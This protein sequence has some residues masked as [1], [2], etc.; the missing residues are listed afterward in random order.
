MTSQYRCVHSGLCRFSKNED[1]DCFG[2]DYQIP[3]SY[4]R[5]DFQSDT[6]ILNELIEWLKKHKSFD[7]PSIRRFIKIRRG[8]DV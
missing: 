8:G 6:I 2:E 5:G 4:Y 1:G 3:C 7:A